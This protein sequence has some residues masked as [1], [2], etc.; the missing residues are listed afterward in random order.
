MTVDIRDATPADRTAWEKLWAEY[1]AFYALNLAPE[2]TERTWA[3][4][5]DPTCPLAGRFAFEDGQMLGFVHHHHHCS[6]WIMGDDCYLED[7]FVTGTA[8]GKGIGRALLDDLCGLARTKGWHRLH[9]HTGEE[10]RHARALYD[11][12]TP[13]DDHV[14]YRLTL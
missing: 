1:L 3:R 12:Y 4:L 13:R 9:W 11:S 10:N 5:I 6:T 14:R 7:L 2:V 8:R